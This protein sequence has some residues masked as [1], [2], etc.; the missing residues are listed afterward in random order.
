MVTVHK[1]AA[2]V[3]KSFADIIKNIW[4]VKAKNTKTSE[5][6]LT[7]TN[8]NPV[9]E[10]LLH[11]VNRRAKLTLNKT[12]VPNRAQLEMWCNP[13]LST[14][15]ARFMSMK[16]ADLSI[17][18]RNLHE[19]SIWFTEAGANYAIS[20]RDRRLRVFLERGAA[21]KV[22]FRDGICQRSASP[23]NNSNRG[24]MYGKAETTGT[25]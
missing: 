2:A 3:S 17:C 12:V 21:R 19:I 5:A 13:S 6:L 22:Q 16:N 4:N 18:S 1:K 20:G 9:K 10:K 23:E 11:T 7:K 24:V 15:E 8:K 25:N 14:S